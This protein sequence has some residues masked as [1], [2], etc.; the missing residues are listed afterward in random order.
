[1]VAV[2]APAVATPDAAIAPAPTPTTPTAAATVAPATTP[3]STAAPPAAATTLPLPAAVVAL[4]VVVIFSEIV[5][6]PPL[7]L[8]VEA[9]SVVE[10]ALGDNDGDREGLGLGEGL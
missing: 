10:P 1:V 5:G 9:A 4:N 2:V 8:P 7:P 6:W 3:A